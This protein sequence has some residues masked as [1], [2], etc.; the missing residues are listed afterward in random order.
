MCEH[1]TIYDATSRND[2]YMHGFCVE[3]G[4]WFRG[5][6]NTGEWHVVGRYEWVEEVVTPHPYT[7]KVMGQNWWE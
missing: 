5:P 7:N 2:L 6:R 3:C 1:E 4:K